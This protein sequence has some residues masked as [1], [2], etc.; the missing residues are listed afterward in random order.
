MAASRAMAS[1]EGGAFDLQGAVA[2][3][4]Y[5]ESQLLD[6]GRFAEWLALFADDGLYWLP[7]VREQVD[8]LGIPSII[9]EDVGIL[10]MRVER[11]LEA[12]ALVLTPMPR[13]THLVTNIIVDAFDETDVKVDAA[14]LVVEQQDGRKQIYAGRSSYTLRRAGDS[15]RIALKRVELMDCDG[16]HA[17]IT[18]PL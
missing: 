9:Y 2:R 10:A 5:A 15:F 16:V 7:S 8:P 11:L 18:I 3:F 1:D 4:L 14:F 12:R 6:C 17:P 13:T